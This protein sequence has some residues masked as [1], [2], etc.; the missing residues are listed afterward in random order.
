[1]KRLYGTLIVFLLWPAVYGERR[2]DRTWENAVEELKQKLQYQ[3]LTG[4]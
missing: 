2:M 4:D 1:M 3:T